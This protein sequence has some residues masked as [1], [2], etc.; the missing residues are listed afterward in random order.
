MNSYAKAALVAVSLICG[1]AFLYIP[2]VAAQV[3]GFFLCALGGY[4]L[5]DLAW[6][7]DR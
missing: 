2:I 3:T 6:E 1:T 7:A 5:M 4:N